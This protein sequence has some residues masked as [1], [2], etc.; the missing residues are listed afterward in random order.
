MPVAC[1]KGLPAMPGGKRC[2]GLIPRHI[3]QYA[4]SFISHACPAAQQGHP[5]GVSCFRHRTPTGQGHKIRKRTSLGCP[6]FHARRSATGTFQ[7]NHRSVF[8]EEVRSSREVF[9][10]AGSDRR[11]PVGPCPLRRRKLRASTATQSLPSSR[12]GPSLLPTVPP[13]PR[14][15]REHPD[16]WPHNWHV[17]TH[18]RTGRYAA[19]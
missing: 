19:A 3:R 6:L 18:R 1:P 9:F 8:G 11:R 12:T 5:P 4:P 7:K 13:A 10:S 17:R 15:D 2:T 16:G 14:R